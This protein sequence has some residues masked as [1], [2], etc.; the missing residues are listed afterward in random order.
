M[1]KANRKGFTLAELLIVVAIIAVLVAISIPIFND[2]LKKARKAVNESNGR[3]AYSA[4]MAEFIN[5]SYVR[6][7][8][9]EYDVSTG[10]ASKCDYNTYVVTSESTPLDQRDIDITDFATVSWDREDFK[11]KIAK[12]WQIIFWGKG[13]GETTEKANI[14]PIYGD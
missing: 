13:P 7:A 1:N 8:M 10:L 12:K 3:A 2:Q 6:P 4:I 9:Y 5:D 11:T 14:K